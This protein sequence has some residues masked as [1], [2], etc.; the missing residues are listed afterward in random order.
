MFQG[1]IQLKEQFIFTSMYELCF[2]DIMLI[3]YFL[4]FTCN[5]NC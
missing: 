3:D 5:S 4:N 2:D 1:V